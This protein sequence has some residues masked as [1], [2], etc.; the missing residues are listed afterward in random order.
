MKKLQPIKVP[1]GIRYLSDWPNNPLNYIFTRPEGSSEKFILDKKMPGCGLTHWCLTNEYPV[2]LCSPRKILLENKADQLGNHVFLVEMGSELGVDVVLNL[3]AID[4]EKEE[5]RR[6]LKKINTKEK[7]R[8]VIIG[9]FDKLQRDLTNYLNFK[10]SMGYPPK[11]LV[12]Y[13]S[14]GKILEIIDDYNR[15][16]YGIPLENYTIVVDEFQSMFTDARFKGDTE[17]DLS[18]FLRAYKVRSIFF[19]SA[20][21]MMDKYLDMI[22]IFQ[23]CEYTFLDWTSLDPTRL[24]RPT[25]IAKGSTKPLRNVEQEIRAYLR[26]DFTRHI[27]WEN[28]KKKEEVSRELIIYVN[29][30]NRILSLIK[31][32]DLGLTPENTCILCA[33]TPSNEKRLKDIGGGWEIGRIPLAGEPRKMFTFCTS[34]VYLGADFYSDNARSIVL[35]DVNISSLIVDISL[36]LPQIIGRQR[37]NYRWSNEVTLYFQAGT[38]PQDAR[39]KKDL[40]EKKLQEK[41]NATKALM[42]MFNG[43]YTEEQERESVVKSLTKGRGDNYEINYITIQKDSNSGSLTAEPNLFVYAAELR[44]LEVQCIDYAD[45]FSVFNTIYDYQNTNYQHDGVDGNKIREII[46]K[47]REIQNPND[48]L[49]FLSYCYR[50]L[51]PNETNALFREI[52]DCHTINMFQTVGIDF[53]ES[54]NFDYEEVKVRYQGLRLVSELGQG[55]DTDIIVSNLLGEGSPE[56][57]K[58]AKTVYRYIKVGEFISASNAKKILTKIYNGLGVGSTALGSHMK[59]FFVL[60]SKKEDGS[61]LVWINGKKCRGYK[62]ISKLY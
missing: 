17:H 8:E 4:G 18:T 38:S 23:D 58:L 19:A 43:P 60:D 39:L 30:V 42:K 56:F 29:A 7:P 47:Y 26:G 45:R 22:D 61:T 52:D 57:V 11:I 46:M 9:E 37:R 55:K 31:T 2:I 40:I 59:N 44:G 51:T 41:V 49:S 14:L 15:R 6:D 3:P 34:T 13:D 27:E 16:G 35:A 62:P 48:K 10:D 1:K 25:I 20:T 32:K 12:T 21:P 50:N 5:K 33:R 53:I 54:V 28:G 24:I 36:D